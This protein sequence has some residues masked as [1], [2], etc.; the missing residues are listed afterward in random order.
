MDN[1]RIHEEAQAVKKLGEEIGYGHLMSL[2]SA[3]WRE[4]LHDKGYPITGAFVAS[5]LYDVKMDD[6]EDQKSFMD[7]LEFYDKLIRL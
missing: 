3:L 2:A 6:D 1:E 4:S 5:L 7:D